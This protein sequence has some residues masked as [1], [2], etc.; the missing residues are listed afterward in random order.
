MTFMTDFDQT[1]TKAKFPDGSTADNSF[2]AIIDYKKTPSKVKE[3]CGILFRKYLPIERNPNISLEE[4]SK[5]MLDW[6]T[7]DLTLFSNAGFN[8]A[9]FALMALEGKLLFRKNTRQLIKTCHDNNIDF[10]VVSGGIY[11]YVESSL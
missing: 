6:W 1:L 2:K 7:G 10:V 11:E 4:K 8:R 9:D 5:H 3:E